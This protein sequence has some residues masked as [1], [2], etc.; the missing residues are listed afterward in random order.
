MTPNGELL[1][2][3]GPVVF[4]LGADADHPQLIIE[5]VSAEVSSPDSG[6]VAEL[7]SDVAVFHLVEPATG[8][9]PLGLST[10]PVSVGDT[11]SVVGF[12]TDVADGGVGAT[13]RPVRRTGTEVLRAVDGNVFDWIYGG[14]SSYL[15]RA[16]ADGAPADLA[17]RYAHGVLL[18]GYEVWATD[19]PAQTC[20]GDSVGPVM[21]CGEP[22]EIVGVTSWSWRSAARLCDYGTVV[23]VFGRE[24][25]AFLQ[26]TLR[27]EP[28]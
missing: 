8:V 28:R 21:R 15:A 2:G 17:A 10:V 22:M 6:G 26:G 27:S 16:P 23:A 9:Q 13:F 24:T 3:R 5:V 4:A 1:L 25:L 7:G 12:G 11:L 20:H 19:A 14:Y 18:D